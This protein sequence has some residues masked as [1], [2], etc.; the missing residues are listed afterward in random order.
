[1]QII[2]L[3]GNSL[4]S[5]EDPTPFLNTIKK[6]CEASSMKS[7]I[8]WKEKNK[9]RVDTIIKNQK[10]KEKKE[11]EEAQAEDERREKKKKRI[12]KHSIICIVLFILGVAGHKSGQPLEDFVVGILVIVVCYFHYYLIIAIWKLLFGKK[13]N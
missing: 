9:K 1:M 11:W 6:T 4:L 13:N 12:I 2:D 7:S 10:E 3:D 8:E 5:N